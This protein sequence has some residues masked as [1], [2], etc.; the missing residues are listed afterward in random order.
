MKSKFLIFA[1]VV[2]ISSLFL[3]AC[4]DSEPYIDPVEA[5]FTFEDK[6]YKTGENINFTNC[7]QYAFSYHWSFG[8]G[9]TSQEKHPQYSYEEAGTYS[10]LLTA[11][12]ENEEHQYVRDV[13]V[14]S[15][16]DLDILVMYYLTEDPVRDCEVTLYGNNEDWA[17]FNNPI[18]TKITG[19]N[20]IVLFEDLEA[21]PYFVDAYKKANDTL[22]YSNELLGI[23]TDPL[24]EDQVNYYN[25]YVELLETEEQPAK[26]RKV[27]VIKK[28]EKTH[29]ND[30][31]RREL[32]EN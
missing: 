5:C 8:D 26:S 6:E 20:G 18:E 16:T 31:F 29:K 13:T 11:Y 28:I 10:V 30:K 14:K 24:E 23:S 19:E 4:K 2:F 25:M 1:S 17:N 32:Y 22:Y 3:G 7:S 27:G 9:A 12:G 15:S 21:K